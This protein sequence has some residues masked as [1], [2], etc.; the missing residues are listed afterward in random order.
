MEIKALIL[1]AGQGKRLKPHTNN[2]PKCLVHLAGKPILL[3]QIKTLKDNNIHDIHIAT[4]YCSKQIEKLGFETSFN[5]KFET[6]NMVETLFCAKDFIDTKGDLIIAYGDIVYNDEN[7]KKLLACDEEI[8]LMIDKSWKDLWNI[9][10]ENPL[11]DAETLIL[12]ENNYVIELG[13]KPENYTRIQGQY[14]G[15]IK[16]RS[17]K[18]KELIKFY[19]SLNKKATYDGKDFFNM[20]MTSFLQLLID[21]NWNVKAVLVDNGWLEIDTVADLNNYEEMVR[22]NTLNSF[23]RIVD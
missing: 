8:C 9:R 19:N 15:L 13:K 4:G 23:Y 11:Q 22:E 6:T 10:L 14:T 7:L 18:I 3:R 1:A 2:M 16:V 21:N 5:P 12:D 20:Y 17:D